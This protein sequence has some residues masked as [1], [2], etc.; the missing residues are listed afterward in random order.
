MLTAIDL[1][2]VISGAIFGVLLAQ[3]AYRIILLPEFSSGWQGS[4]PD[5]PPWFPDSTGRHPAC[6]DWPE[7]FPGSPESLPG[8]SELSV[9]WKSL[10]PP[11]QCSFKRVLLP[12]RRNCRVQPQCRIPGLHVLDSTSELLSR[13]LRCSGSTFQLG[14]QCPRLRGLFHQT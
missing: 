14:G 6:P 12:L 3:P 11:Y 8:S 5:S 1:L 7:F 13:N 9:N 2:A 10:H 4:Q